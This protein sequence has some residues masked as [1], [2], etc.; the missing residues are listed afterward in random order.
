MKLSPLQLIEYHVTKLSVEACASFL[1]DKPMDLDPS[2][3]E[4]DADVKLLNDGEHPRWAVSLILRHEPKDGKNVPYRL[5][6]E[7]VGLVSSFA[8][9]VDDA[10]NHAVQVN[11]PSM[12]FGAAREILRDATARG[13]HGPIM[14]PSASFFTTP[15]PTNAPDGKPSQA[16]AKKGAR[17]RRGH[18]HAE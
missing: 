9:K 4:V 11:G 13:P 5:T 17:H 16:S 7:M 14:I 1:R 6:L 12:L 8:N 15:P 18:R 10:I 2:D 3:L